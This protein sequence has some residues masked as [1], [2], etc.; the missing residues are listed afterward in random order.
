[1]TDRTVL[2]D[3]NIL[4]ALAL[5]SHVHHREAHRAL[6]RIEGSWATC[7]M[8]EAGFYRLLLNPHVTGRPFTFA[9]I[10]EVLAGM[11]SDPRWCFLTDTG[12]LTEPVIDTSVLVGH[13]QVTDFHLVDLAA[14]H[15]A[16][17]ATFD[18]GLPAGLA[19]GDRGHVLVLL[20]L[21]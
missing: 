13:Q 3:V 20:G 15:G 18:A 21:D 1:M 19:P 2:L 16:V 17:L 11:R 4:V 8:T 10:S 7:P 9:E 12:T 14:R 5:D 6:N